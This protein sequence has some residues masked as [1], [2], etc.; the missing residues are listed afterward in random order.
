MQ[1]TC[2]KLSELII[3]Q[4]YKKVRSN[5]ANYT[6]R[7]IAEQVAQ[8]VAFFAKADAYEQDRLGEAMFANDQFISVYRALSLS[9]DADDNKYVL[10][11]STPAG[12][13]Q[14]REV[15]YVGFTGNKTIQVLPMRNKD[16]FMQSLTSTPQWMCL[17]YVEDGKIIFQNLSPLITGTVDLKLVGAIPSGTNLVDL[18]L[19]VPKSTETMIFDK[20]LARMN[21][22]ANKLPDQ[23]LDNVSK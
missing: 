1:M 9:T 5:D 16:R 2:G 23:I 7:H 6:L 8:E 18:P 19:N 13:P 17:Y 11:P 20:I 21:A 22:L 10:M 14:G 3:N 12:M 4:Y 15:A